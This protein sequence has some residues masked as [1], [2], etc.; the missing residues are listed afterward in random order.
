MNKDRKAK[1]ISAKKKNLYKKIN[2]ISMQME[3][4]EKQTKK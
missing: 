4:L 3:M 1:Q 2:I